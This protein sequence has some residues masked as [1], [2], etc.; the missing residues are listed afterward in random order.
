MRRLFRTQTVQYG[1]GYA[2]SLG[3]RTL[4]DLALA[5]MLGTVQFG[6]WASFL[7]A[8]QYSAYSD[9]G[10]T[11]GLSRVL[12][13]AL[14]QSDDTAV[15]RAMGVAWL[16]AM[17]ATAAAA[18][19]LVV[20]QALWGSGGGLLTWGLLALLV[21]MFLDKHQT[22]SAAV[23]ASSQR[24]G[25]SGLFLG[26]LGATELLLCVGFASLIGINGAYLGAVGGI[27]L[28]LV[29]MYMRQ[30]I[31]ARPTWD[32]AAFRPLAASSFVLMGFGL[33]NVAMHNLDR[34]AIILQRGAGAELA[35]Y[36]IASLLSLVVNVL[37]YIV[38][39]VL[40]PKLYRFGKDSAVEL[41]P[42]LLLP[43]ATMAVC[44]VAVAS[45]AWLLAP[46]FVRLF[47]PA[48]DPNS[49]LLAPLLLSE[50]SFSIAMVAGNISVAQDRGAVALGVRIGLVLAGFAG[51]LAILGSGGGTTGVAWVMS[52]VQVVGLLALGLLASRA[53]AVPFARFLG[54]A[55]APMAYGIAVQVAILGVLGP[56]QNPSRLFVNLV[57][58]VVF[59]S[60]LSIIA[61]GYVGRGPLCAES[62]QKFLYRTGDA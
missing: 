27:L 22:Y 29:V 18:A 50:L 59:L 62:A 51:S 56:A 38:L 52:G 34:V 32:L 14:N 42:Y 19:S 21:V 9:L 58:T 57:I 25:E 45:F 60:P 15:E 23:Y 61:L 7:V 10:F 31:R 4:R 1:F 35:A 43:S 37:P 16:T 8:R 2:V 47:L 44:G 24:V 39:T 41:R 5:R 11:N 13:L 53:L 49:N 20:W 6:L 26:Q 48:F 30:P 17:G 3:S 33:T 36:H 46:L 12:P 55:I 40:T 28:T 54:A